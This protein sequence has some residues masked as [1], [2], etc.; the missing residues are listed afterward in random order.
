MKFSYCIGNPPY[1]VSKE[2]TSDQPVY[3]EFMDAAYQVA[4]KVELI[5]PARFL[6]N[7]GKT[8]KPWNEKMLNDEHFKILTFNADS[9]AFFPKP[10][11][12]KGGVAIHYRDAN[13]DF[14]AI[15]V[16]TAF[17]ELNTIVQKTQSDENLSSITYSQSA[18]RISEMFHRELPD[19]SN[20]LGNSAKHFFA[21]NVFEVLSNAVFFDE[22]P[23]DGDY[24]QLYGRQNNERTTK[25][26]AKKYVDA[27][28]NLNKYKVFLPKSNGSGALG[29]TLST[30]VVGHPVVGH[31]QTFISIGCFDTETEANNCLKYIKTKFARCLVGVLKGTQDNPPAVWAKVPI[32]DFTSDS[33]IDWS[34]SISDIDKQ[35]YKK[36]G[37]SEDEIKFIEKNVKEMK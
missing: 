11:D 18:Y 36:Y 13:A 26:V 21:S 20:K 7:N 2:N 15:K 10:V 12:I 25:Y 1:Q 5:T 37:L 35:L 23:E 32:Q 17:P 3:N 14:G 19:E 16:F 9:T 27:P 33:D 8:P 4:D 6:F 34:Q 29:E 22:K 31:T 28:N 30:P 24:I